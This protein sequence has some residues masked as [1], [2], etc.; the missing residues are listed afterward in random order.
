M[1]GT[2]FD[3]VDAAIIKTDGRNLIKFIDA[4]FIPYTRKERA[5]YGASFFKNYNYITNF[6]NNK[7][8]KAI[9]KLLTK[10]NFSYDSI[11][12]IGL[13][14]Q[15]IKHKPEEKWSWQNI[16][17]LKFVKTFKTNVISDFRLNDINNGG[18]G[19]PLVPVYHANIAKSYLNDL[20]A[21]IINIGGVSNVT[22]VKRDGSFLGYDIGPG[23]GPI[24]KIVSNKFNLNFDKDGQ[25]SKRGI[26]NS[27]IIKKIISDIETLPSKRSYDRDMLDKICLKNVLNLSPA[28]AVSTITK[29]IASLIYKKVKKYKPKKVIFVGGGRKNTTLKKHLDKMFKNIV[30]SAEEI[31]WDGDSIEAQAFAYLAVRSLFGLNI[32]F[33]T[34]TGVA[35]PLSGGILY[36]YN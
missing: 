28:D 6:I 10:T 23:N 17:A 19:A 29:A 2:S 5:L 13:H 4:T 21:A 25:I 34:T 15:T 3:G 32:S 8:I 22:I 14:G 1:S 20:P 12:V 11:D 7:H 33:P 30:I 27:G 26:I 9:K 35:S 24:D 36:N 31:G 16:D 18:E